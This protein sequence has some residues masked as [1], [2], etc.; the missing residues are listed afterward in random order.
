M[1]SISEK[2]L[3][4]KINHVRKLADFT[5]LLNDQNAILKKQIETLKHK[6]CSEE[7]VDSESQVDSR[8]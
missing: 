8:S 4:E 1:D 3:N 6:K 5:I 2:E 7:S